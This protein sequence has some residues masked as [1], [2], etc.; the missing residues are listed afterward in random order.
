MKIGRTLRTLQHLRPTQVV[1][2]AKR[3]ITSRLDASRPHWWVSRVQAG[4]DATLRAS[5][6]PQWPQTPRPLAQPMLDDSKPIVCGQ[7]LQTSLLEVNFDAEHLSALAQVNLHA[8]HFL[9]TSFERP[10]QARAVVDAWIARYPPTVQPA[11]SPWCIARRVPGWLRLLSCHPDVGDE[12][13][14]Q[15]LGRQVEALSTRIEF[16]LQGNHLWDDAVALYLAG[17]ALDSKRSSAWQATGKRLLHQ[18][19]VKQVLPCGGHAE[20]SVMYHCSL[21]VGLLELMAGL[22]VAGQPDVVVSECA[23]SM[24]RWLERI[25]PLSGADPEFNDAVAGLYPTAHQVLTAAWRAGLGSA[26][27]EP[28]HT[29]NLDGW[30]LSRQGSHYLLLDAADVGLDEQPGHAHADTLCLDWRVA[31]QPILVDPG[32]A[33]YAAD[34]HR[35]WSRST[36]AHGVLTLGDL[37]SAEV[38]HTFRVGRRPQDVQSHGPRPVAVPVG[39][40]WS[41]TG[42]HDGYR[43]LTGAPIVRRE[44]MVW[45]LDDINALLW[46]ADSV[47][48]LPVEMT[49]RMT[50]SSEL[51]LDADQIRGAASGGWLAFGFDEHQLAQGRVSGGVGSW[52]SAPVV[53]GRGTSRHSGWVLSVGDKVQTARESAEVEVAWQGK[54]IA[55]LPSPDTP[56]SQRVWSLC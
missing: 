42:S 37:D 48:G 25:L 8:F 5:W 26:S 53:V 46:I 4:A 38:W 30:A 33:E 31:G 29:D 28:E 12:Q 16:D 14:L 18:A 22:E 39:Q 51:Q 45:W 13:R 56:H 35:A 19:I 54:M 32:I 50:F 2:R 9:P 36:R 20:R 34:P 44:V 11:W 23:D 1:G 3:V 47:D 40:A 17:L 10:D 52:K 6:R 43:H 41:M 15:S 55:S 27:I 24:A 7:N 21:L 49:S